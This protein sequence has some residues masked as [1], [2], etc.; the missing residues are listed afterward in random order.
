MGVP[1]ICLRGDR[2]AARVGASILT[3]VGQPN[4][5][6]E[7]IEDYVAVAGALAKDQVR[8]ASLRRSLRPAMAASPLCDAQG[9]TRDVET[10]FTNMWQKWCGSL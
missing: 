2:H 4:L 6:A 7:T 5:I 8:L 10:A 1:V 3:R 9:F